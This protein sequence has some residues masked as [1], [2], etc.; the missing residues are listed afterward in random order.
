[1]FTVHNPVS[2]LKLRLKGKTNVPFKGYFVLLVS[3]NGPKMSIYAFFEFLPVP[4]AFI[5]WI[6]YQ[7]VFKKKEWKDIRSDASVIGMFLAISGLLYYWL[8]A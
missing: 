6:V 8:F 4:I 5:G 1:M 3:I 7:L 2:K